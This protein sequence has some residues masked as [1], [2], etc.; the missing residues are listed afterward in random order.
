M[1]SRATA[2]SVSPRSRPRTSSSG[3]FIFPRSVPGHG[4]RFSIYLPRVDEAAESVPAVDPPATLDARGDET[5]LVVD[6]E[7]LILEL[8]RRV[9]GS[10]G[11][12][13]LRASSGGASVSAACSCWRSRSRRSSSSS[14]CGS[15]STVRRRR[16]EDASRGFGASSRLRVRRA[17]PFCAAFSLRRSRHIAASPSVTRQRYHVATERHGRHFSPRRSTSFGVT[18]LRTR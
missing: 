3:G 17:Y 7:P 2:A 12:R 11:Y 6:D 8:A 9:L 10:H 5:V 16:S 15:C 14:G 4:T 1:T 18:F 13:V